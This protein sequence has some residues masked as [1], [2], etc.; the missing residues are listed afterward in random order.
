MLGAVGF[1][2][3]ARQMRL[4]AVW[5]IPVAAAIDRVDQ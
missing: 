2:P 4:I 5:L 3:Q 1:S